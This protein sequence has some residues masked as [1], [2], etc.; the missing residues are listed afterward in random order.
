LETAEE[1][2]RRLEAELEAAR[3]ALGEQAEA[4]EEAERLAAALKLAEEAARVAKLTARML[5]ELD[6][7]IRA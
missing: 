3:L 6:R 2:Q 7:V 1:R 4:K 5:G